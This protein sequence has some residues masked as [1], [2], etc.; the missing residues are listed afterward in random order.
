MTHKISKPDEEWKKILTAKQFDVCRNKG[1][2]RAFTGMYWDTKDDGVYR[3]ICC[4]TELFLLTQN[5]IQVLV[6]QVS[7]SLLMRKI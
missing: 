1:T 4:S 2:E 7:L 3:C 6:G 5:L